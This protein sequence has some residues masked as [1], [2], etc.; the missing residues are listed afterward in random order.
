MN[1][2]KAVFLLILISCVCISCSER[3]FSNPFDPA[4]SPRDWVPEDLTVT[5]LSTSSVRLDWKHPGAYRISTIIDRQR[6]SQEEFVEIGRVYGT[7]Y[8]DSTLQPGGTYT[9]RLRAAIDDRTSDPTTGQ[10]I[11][12][13]NEGVLVWEENGP[14]MIRTLDF[15]HTSYMLVAGM[16]DGTIRAYNGLDG[17]LIWSIQAAG[18]VEDMDISADDTRFVAGT[19]QNT[20]LNTENTLEV[21]DL[22]NGTVIWQ[23]SFPRQMVSVCFSPDG[24][25]LASGSYDY[26]VRLHQSNDGILLW[27]NSN[28]YHINKVDISP[29]GLFVASAG[30][31]HY[32]NI[33]KWVDGSL[34]WQADCSREVWDVNISGDNTKIASGDLANGLKI[35]NVDT[36]SLLWSD[37]HSGF[38]DLDI[39]PSDRSVTCAFTDKT[40]CY[41]LANGTMMWQYPKAGKIQYNHGGNKIGIFDN[42]GIV[43]ILDSETGDSLWSGFHDDSGWCMSFS[44]DDLL[45]TTGGMDQMI[46]VWY[47]KNAWIKMD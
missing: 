18:T 32:L 28:G 43:R 27:E 21:G 17:T 44:Y 14:S 4:I 25:T 7:T 40:C 37:I 26:K 38:T 39:H 19:S 20:D 23:E 30:W 36:G 31:D 33:W 29:D 8:T 42:N 1:K 13:V 9:Y 35:W 24:H 6:N 34:L 41:I 47:A 45:L 12:W 2:I 22:A 3:N 10:S 15:F 5:I 16:M 46:K 11:R